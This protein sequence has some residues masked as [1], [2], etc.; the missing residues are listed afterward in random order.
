MGTLPA[1]EFTV[2]HWIRIEFSSLL[3]RDVRMGVLEAD[4]A[5]RADARF[6][7][8]LD[9]SFTVLLPTA[10]DFATTKRY[11]AKFE[12]A[13]RSGDALHLAVA[14]NRDARSIYSLDATLLKAGKL[15]DLP[16]S[17]G[18]RRRS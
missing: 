8:M 17:A 15:L 2:S 11:L 16:V 9:A 12:T 14:N 4:A 10:D 6:E 7:A 3:A 5:K 13:L 1:D 18:I